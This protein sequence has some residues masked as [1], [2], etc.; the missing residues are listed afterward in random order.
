MCSLHSLGQI[1]RERQEPDCISC[2]EEAF[3]LANQTG[4]SAAAATCA[5][6]LGRAYMEIPAI[7][8]PNK[9]E[10]EYRRSLGLHSER[11]LHGRGRCHCGIAVVAV[12]RF[13][14]ARD[15]GEPY[16]KVHVLFRAALKA[17]EKAL[18]LIPKD[19]MNDRATTHNQHAAILC[20]GGD[21][22]SA[23]P[24]FREALR[25]YDL[26]GNTFGAAQTRSNVA[27]L[28]EQSGLPVDAR[29]YAR[30]ARDGFAS[31]GTAAAAEVQKAE[32]L[33]DRLNKAIVGNN[34]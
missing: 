14:K 25:I 22:D 29:E 1:R 6:N 15:A 27:L 32:E 4:D 34:L 12:R 31:Y 33:I 18:E 16:A 5:F 17:S 8:D 24:H 19:A 11:D 10:Q 30:A 2:Y 9:A 23:L 7:H 21:I 13:E 26:V 20:Y 28:L 3:D